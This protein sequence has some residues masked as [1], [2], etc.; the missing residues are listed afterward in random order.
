MTYPYG[1][2][3]PRWIGGINRLAAIP[4]TLDFRTR[5]S[6]AETCLR[7]ISSL[8]IV[9][10]NSTRVACALV[11][12]M[13]SCGCLFGLLSR[14]HFTFSEPFAFIYV[15]SSFPSLQFHLELWLAGLWFLNAFI[16][17]HQIRIKTLRARDK[18]LLPAMTKKKQ[19]KGEGKWWNGTDAL[20]SDEIL[21]AC[22]EAK[23]RIKCECVFVLVIFATEWGVGSICPL[24]F[25]LCS[26]KTARSTSS[27]VCY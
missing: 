2:S 20:A 3:P 27:S 8:I 25:A 13:A 9:S 12:C 24:H 6:L 11:E 23:F 18:A 22:I 10:L 7:R 26:C 5:K 4:G 19:H 15:Q 16:D 17:A 14:A 21:Y 1:M